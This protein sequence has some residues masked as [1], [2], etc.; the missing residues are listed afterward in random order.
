MQRRTCHPTF[1]G[2]TYSGPLT[3]R[4]MKETLAIVGR[5]QLLLDDEHLILPWISTRYM[6]NQCFHRKVGILASVQVLDRCW[7]SSE[8]CRE[9]RNQIS[10][11]PWCYLSE[12]L[13]YPHSL[14]ISCLTFHEYPTLLMADWVFVLAGILSDTCRAAHGLIL[15][16][17]DANL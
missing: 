4:N 2:P 9:L 1:A 6:S 3:C 12:V 15:V 14:H 17:T 7:P 8:A 16:F 11:P 13:S 5:T 10:P